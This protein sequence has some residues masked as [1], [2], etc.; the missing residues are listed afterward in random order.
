MDKTAATRPPD[1]DPALAAL[2]DR[3]S[4]HPAWGFGYVRCP[5]CDSDRLSSWLREADRTHAPWV[6]C[7]ACGAR[8]GWARAIHADIC[9]QLARF[10]CA[11]RAGAA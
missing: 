4:L 7:D 11:V 8:L 1:V 6:A 9:A 10:G 2:L 3:I 5:I